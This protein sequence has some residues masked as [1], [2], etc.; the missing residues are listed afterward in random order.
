MFDDDDDG[1]TTRYYRVSPSKA[2]GVA[3]SDQ[4]AAPKVF[5]FPTDLHVPSLDSYVLKEKK[6]EIPGK[7]K[8]KLYLNRKLDSWFP[9]CV[10]QF[11]KMNRKI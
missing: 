10:I 6:K 11:A 3:G 2:K 7:I 5:K 1:S 8:K 4:W 9:N